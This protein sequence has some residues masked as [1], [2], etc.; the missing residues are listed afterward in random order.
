MPDTNTP[1][2]PT[3]PLAGRV[4]VVTGTSRGIGRAIALRLE[5]LGARVGSIQRGDGV[6]HAVRADLADAALAEAAVAELARELGPID[7]C[8]AAH[9]TT[10]RRPALDVT[11]AEWRRVIDV[12]LSGAFA[13]TR[14]AAR[15]MV[16][17]GGAIVHLASE[18]A[19]FGGVEIAPYAASKGGIVQL[20]K[21][22]ANEWAPLGIRVNAVAPGWIET[23]LT[24]PLRADRDRHAEI[25]ARIPA[26]RWGTPEE[27]AHA[28]AWLVSDDASYVSGTVLV[29]DGGYLAR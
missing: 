11:L 17:R 26:G 1:H 12:N 19:F 3:R 21:S 28:A 25:S 29:V 14:A 24:A 10:V 20:M 13:V 2:A 23:E 18:L 8:V 27:I 4:A 22:Q 5:Q 9:G 15:E 6:G 16:G 7:V